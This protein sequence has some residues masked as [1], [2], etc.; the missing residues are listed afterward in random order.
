M[1]RSGVRYY[2]LS[3][4]INSQSVLR[5]DPFC[6]VIRTGSIAR[7]KSN[8]HPIHYHHVVKVAVIM[9]IEII[10]SACFWVEKSI[11]RV[12]ANHDKL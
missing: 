1:N 8:R 12:I 9:S 6:S 5:N 10:P 2:N 7:V 4:K 11:V 3:I